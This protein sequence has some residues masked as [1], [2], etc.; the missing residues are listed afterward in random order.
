[1]NWKKTAPDV[2]I[3][4]KKKSAFSVVCSLTMCKITP[5]Y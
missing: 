4:K 3:K 5:F 2:H 1:M